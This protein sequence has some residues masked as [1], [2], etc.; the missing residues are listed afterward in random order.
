M[1]KRLIIYGAGY[2]DIV[3]LINAINCVEPRWEIAGFVDD[4]LEKH[5]SVFMQHRIIADGSQLA[6][7][8]IANTWFF[9]NVYRTTTMRRQVSKR[10]IDAGCRL[11][12]LI[13]P[14]IELDFTSIGE[15]TIINQGVAIGAN[16]E[17]GSHCAIRFNSVVNH[18]SVIEDFVFVGPGVTL[19]GRV[20]I[21]NGAYVGAGSIIRE[22]VEIGE[23]SIIGAGAVVL[24]D[25]PAG[26]CVGGVP[27][28][29]L[30]KKEK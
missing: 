17:I 30:L 20:T 12:T 24:K 1:S 19:C 21:R 9:N 7:L 22:C 3:K 5:G 10:F 26:Q 15:D 8:N 6:E 28:K 11:A 13:H 27:A 23:D 2:P 25:V 18:E 4:T 29:E 16:V 14:S